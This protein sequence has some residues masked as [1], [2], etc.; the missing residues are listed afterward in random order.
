MLAAGSRYETE[1]TNGIAHFAEHMFFKG[2]ER[3][4][5]ARDIAGEIDA[6]GGEFNAFTGKEYTGYYVKCAAEHRDRRAR[7]ARRHAPPL[8]VRPRGDRAREGRDRR[9]DEHVLRHAARLHRR[10][11]RGAPVRRPAARLGHHRHEGDRA[12]RDARDVPR[13]PRPLVPPGAHGRRRSPAASTATCSPRSRRCSATSRRRTAAPPGPRRRRPSSGRG[14]RSTRSTSD[15]A[16]LCLGV[17]SYPARRIPTAT[18]CSCSRP[19][20]AA[21]CRR[22]SSPRCASGAASPTTSSASTTATPTPARSTRR[23]ASTST[24]STRR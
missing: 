10:R 21:A 19:C 11:V 8:E 2:T 20:S 12:R 1:E 9:G 13:L 18:R 3:R 22:A 5:T 15:Q 24:A 17:P 6:I 7:R 14:R 16:H 23:P 4:P